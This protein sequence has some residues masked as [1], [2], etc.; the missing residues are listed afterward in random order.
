MPSI[1]REKGQK[2]EQGRG[3]EYPLY[4]EVFHVLLLMIIY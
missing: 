1:E 3:K 2:G 4:P